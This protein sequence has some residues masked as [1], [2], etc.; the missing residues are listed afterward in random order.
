MMKFIVSISVGALLLVTS[1]CAKPPAK[2]SNNITPVSTIENSDQINCDWKGDVLDGKQSGLQKFLVG[3]WEGHEPPNQGIEMYL[4][5]QEDG[6]AVVDYSQVERNNVPKGRVSYRPYRI[7]ADNT[8]NICGYPD[9]F[10][11][12]RHSKDE[13][14]MVSDNK[15]IYSRGAIEIIYICSFKRVKP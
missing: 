1:F 5:F 6:T 15:G 9:N 4:I 8:L 11:V 13:F 10:T 12:R 2:Q 3:K 7:N 14:S